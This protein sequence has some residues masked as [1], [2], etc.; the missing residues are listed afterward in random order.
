MGLSKRRY[1]FGMWEYFREGI[2]VMLCLHTNNGKH[3]AL[4]NK[5]VNEIKVGERRKEPLAQ[6]THAGSGHGRRGMQER[7]KQNQRVT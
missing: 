2:Y 1:L 3:K 7:L 5:V 6:H 4:P